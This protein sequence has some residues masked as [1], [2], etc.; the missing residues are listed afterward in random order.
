LV[1]SKLN[2]EEQYGFIKLSVFAASCLNLEKLNASDKNTLI[3]LIKEKGSSEFN[4][5]RTYNQFPFDKYFV[6]E[7]LDFVVN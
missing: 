7:L 4:Y 5:I 6:N 1:Y 2:K 3:K